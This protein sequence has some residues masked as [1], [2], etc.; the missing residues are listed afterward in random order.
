M[1]E[2]VLSRSIIALRSA[3][4]SGR[5]HGQNITL[6]GEFAHFGAQIPDMAL[7]VLEDRIPVIEYFAQVLRHLLAPGGDLGGVYAVA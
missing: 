1:M 7:G 4:R 3:A 6:H 2:S 5:A